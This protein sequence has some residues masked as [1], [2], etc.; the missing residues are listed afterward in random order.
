[1]AERWE[2]HLKEDPTSELSPNEHVFFEELGTM[3]VAGVSRLT[4]VPYGRKSLLYYEEQSKDKGCYTTLN[5]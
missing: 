5:I 3:K 4:L 1:M 2:K